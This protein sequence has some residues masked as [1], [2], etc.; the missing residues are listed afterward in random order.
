MSFDEFMHSF[1]LLIKKGKKECD[2]DFFDHDMSPFMIV[3][4]GEMVP[5]ETVKE[6]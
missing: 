4:T 2:V 1:A 3:W 5:P 6:V